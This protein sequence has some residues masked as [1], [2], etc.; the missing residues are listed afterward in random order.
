MTVAIANGSTSTNGHTNGHTNGTNGTHV[1][2]KSHD[3]FGTRAVHVGSEANAETGA[4]IPPI[5]L[6]TTYKQNGVGNHK[7]FEYSRSGNPNRDAL[8]QTLASLETGGTFALAFASGSST[9]ATMI[10]SLGPNAHM[11]SV[12]DVYGGTFRYMARVATAN[13]GL[14]TTFLDLEDLSEGSQTPT[15]PTLRLIDIARL[16]SILDTH[17]SN[18][19]SSRP[20]IL[21]D[22]TFASPFYTS[23]LLLGADVV[24][25]SLTKYINGHSDV[26]MGALIL[27][28]RNHALAEKLRFLQ[29]AIGA[30]PS[31]YDSWLAQRGAKTL[32]LRMKQHGLNAVLVA[33][34]LERSPYVDEVIY[35]G[36][37]PKLSN[38][39]EDKVERAK[40]RYEIAEK[41]L[42]PH[43]SRWIDT[44]SNNAESSESLESHPSFPYSG[45][46][47]FRI[48]PPTPSTTSDELAAL[49]S[50]FLSSLRLF[51]LAESLG[52]VE[53][54][55]EVP[56]RMTHAA[57]PPKER[58]ALGITEGW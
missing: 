51:T 30:V 37:V 35:P 29:N 22:N 15:N 36:F 49:T 24:L 39:N 42:S 2:H 10:Q 57:I 14:E 12:N 54:L 33:Q 32:H 1:A 53:S 11:I 50:D 56:A 3:G 26:V 8:E 23:P 45:M 27:P 47:S 55:C 7:G 43:A 16:S 20:V 18:S 31:A 28:A 52:G 9:T 58:E 4:V 5:S 41:N 19:P 17:F 34:A 13:Q 40:R 21:V 48:R 6:S 46:I 25:H 38:G 44:L